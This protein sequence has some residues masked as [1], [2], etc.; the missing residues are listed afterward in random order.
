MLNIHE[1]DSN[2]AIC[3]FF[4]GTKAPHTKEA[5]GARSVAS[6]AFQVSGVNQ[7]TE[8]KS[9][10]RFCKFSIPSDVRI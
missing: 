8:S 7:L 3:P 6:G 4:Y 9:L 10:C 2:L 5:K 1:F